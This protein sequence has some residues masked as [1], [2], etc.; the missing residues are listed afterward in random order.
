MFYVD[1]SPNSLGVG[2][3]S[4]KTSK[5]YPFRGPVG[6]EDYLRAAREVEFDEAPAPEP[7]SEQ[8]QIAPIPPRPMDF[9]AQVRIELDE[10][11]V[12]KC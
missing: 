6:G 10:M 8:V 5:R 7:E 4:V 11:K 9:G 2:L 1:D 12:K 3:V